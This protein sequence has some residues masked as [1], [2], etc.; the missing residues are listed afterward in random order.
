MSD[1]NLLQNLAEAATAKVNETADRLRA[2]GHATAAENREGIVDKVQDR[3]HE[4]ADRLRAEANEGKAEAAFDRAK[5]QVKE[6]VD[7]LK[8]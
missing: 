4:G 7:S 1:K 2:E 6:A 8:K 5:A 3:L